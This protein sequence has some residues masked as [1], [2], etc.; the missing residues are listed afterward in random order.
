M[1]EEVDWMVAPLKETESTGALK[2][3]V[4]GWLQF[5]IFC[6]SKIKTFFCASHYFYGNLFI[7][8]SFNVL[9]KGSSFH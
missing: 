6:V 7:F 2:D 4:R 5:G 9:F 1:L 8:A 3:S